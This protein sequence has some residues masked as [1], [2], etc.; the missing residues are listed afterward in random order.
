MAA[1]DTTDAR[2][3]FNGWRYPFSQEEFTC[4]MEGRG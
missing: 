3:E 1:S 4:L 2:S